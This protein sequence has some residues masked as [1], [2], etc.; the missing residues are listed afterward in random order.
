MRSANR[1]GMMGTER[2]GGVRR[3]RLRVFT[4]SW[5]PVSRWVAKECKEY[6]QGSRSRTGNE[7]GGEEEAF[8][9]HVF[10][11]RFITQ[12]R[13][14]VIGQSIYYEPALIGS[15]P[16]FFFFLF[17]LPDICATIHVA[18]LDHQE[19]F[20]S[21]CHFLTIFFFFLFKV[22]DLPRGKK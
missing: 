2:D 7:R 22:S 13:S 8:F 10:S 16:F 21:T 12:E 15:T 4:G 20:H 9:E 3:T 17:F 6:K 11:A 14:G 19:P 1:I 18:M 5:R